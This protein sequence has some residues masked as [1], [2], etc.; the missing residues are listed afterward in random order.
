MFWKC[1]RN[2]Y[3]SALFFCSG[4]GPPSPTIDDH[5][6][7]I[8]SAQMIGDKTAWDRISF[9]IIATLLRSPRVAH[10]EHI[11]RRG[12]GCT[13]RSWSSLF[14]A[15]HASA[16]SVTNQ[17]Q[18]KPFHSPGVSTTTSSAKNCSKPSERKKTI[19]RRMVVMLIFR[20][21]FCRVHDGAARRTERC[22]FSVSWRLKLN[23]DQWER[24]YWKLN[25]FETETRSISKLRGFIAGLGFVAKMSSVFIGI[26]LISLLRCSTR[27]V[28]LV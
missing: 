6:T 16:D 17:Q 28:S 25:G 9:M 14:A 27:S 19:T 5:R 24:G 10:G 23:F 8:Y 22:W 18:C 13:G 7:K 3:S 21:W 26:W 11:R 20:L 12:H 2:W 15:A 4:S 1:S